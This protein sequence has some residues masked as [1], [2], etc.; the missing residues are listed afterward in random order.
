MGERYRKGVF[1]LVYRNPKNLEYLIL[2]RKKHWIGWEF[3]KGG[4]E[5]REK[6]SKTILREIKE[7]TGIKI[8][9]MKNE[10]DSGKYLYGKKLSDRKDM[11]GQ[12][13]SL[14]SI[15]F[16]SGRIRLDKREHSD[17]KWVSFDRALKMLTWPN[18]RKCLRIVNK[19]LK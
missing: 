7:E 17:Y 10:R 8:K 3:P 16:S 11:I 12:T 14:Y 19:R 6:I 2:K 13:Y 1:M 5:K 18:Q 15:E 4:I 9:K